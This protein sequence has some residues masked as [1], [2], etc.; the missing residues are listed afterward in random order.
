MKL[1]NALIDEDNVPEPFKTFFNPDMIAEMA[2]HLARVDGDFDRARFIEHAT[3]GMDALEL[4]ERSNQICD[5]L[6]QF[7]PAD[8]R[9]ACDIM[10][11]AL[12]PQDR[13]GLGNMSMDD[14][15]I[16]G[17]AIMP[18]ADLVAR[19]GLKDFD[20]S[21]DVL[22]HLTCRFSAEFAVRHFFVRDWQSALDKAIVWS[23]SDNFHIRRLASEGSRPRLPWG[24]QIAQFVNDPNPLLPL[25]EG[26]KSDEEEYVRRSVANNINDIAKDHPDTVAALAK[27][28][29]EGADKNTTRLVKHACRIL[30]KK[31]HAPTLAALGYGKPQIRVDHFAITTPEVKLG[32]HLAFEMEMTSTADELQPLIIDFAI[33]YQ[34]AN[35]ELSPKVYKWKIIELQA[36]ESLTI[37]KKQTVRQITTRVFHAGT[38]GLEI[39]INGERLAG[40]SFELVL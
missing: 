16:R 10:V 1:H 6:D 12:H 8:H 2:D 19:R 39:Q 11:R 5:A 40:G 27:R 36:N 34:R 24:L 15:G 26:L 22:A 25:L 18:M 28:W 35:G 17:W 14:Q 31:G 20:Y 29:M 33:Q 13:A 4:K 21:L 32:G 23:K 3:A 9:R 30:V 38:H 7:L 37:S